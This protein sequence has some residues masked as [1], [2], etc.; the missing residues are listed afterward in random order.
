MEERPQ[1]PQISPRA[2]TQ[3]QAQTTNMDQLSDEEKV[4]RMW[5]NL[6]FDFAYSGNSNDILNKIKSF[7]LIILSFLFLLRVCLVYTVRYGKI[8]SVEQSWFLRFIIL[9]LLI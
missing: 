4:R 3:T 8:S 9:C 6:D 2:P 1:T 5:S 7:R